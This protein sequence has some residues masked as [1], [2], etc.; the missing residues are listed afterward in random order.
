MIDEEFEGIRGLG[1]EKEKGPT[2]KSIKMQIKT[3]KKA[4]YFP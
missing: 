3:E 2:G 4:I 1:G